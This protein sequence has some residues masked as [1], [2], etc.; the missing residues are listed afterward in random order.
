MCVAFGDKR[1]RHSGKNIFFIAM[2]DAVNDLA[3]KLQ[4]KEVD[5]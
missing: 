2:V 4:W 3:A 1:N 5:Q